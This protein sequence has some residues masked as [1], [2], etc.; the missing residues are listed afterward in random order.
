MF[1]TLE[2]QKIIE[3]D[4]EITILPKSNQLLAEM[5]GAME[6]RSQPSSK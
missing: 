4:A 3:G 5:V 1:A 6:V 2:I